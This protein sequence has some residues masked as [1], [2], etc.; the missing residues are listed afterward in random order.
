MVNTASN[1]GVGVGSGVGVSTTS[2]VTSDVGV[3][4][5]GAVGTGAPIVT[6]TV[7]V[8]P[9]PS[10]AAFEVYHALV[11]IFYLYMTFGYVDHSVTLN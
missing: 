5:G 11:T 10:S 4:T 9:S 3:S 1:P 2:D 8:F 6:V 7:S